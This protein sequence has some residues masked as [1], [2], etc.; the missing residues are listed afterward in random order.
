MGR[1]VELTYCCINRIS[2]T[3][4]GLSFCSLCCSSDNLLG[5]YAI[6]LIGSEFSGDCVVTSLT[7]CGSGSFLIDLVEEFVDYIGRSP[8]G[9]SFD[10]FL[11]DPHVSS[12]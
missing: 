9:Q 8:I 10:I 2:F 12:S 4:Q 1:G 11:Y 3:C 6:N 7:E 5:F